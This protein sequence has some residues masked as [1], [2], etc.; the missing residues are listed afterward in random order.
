MTVQHAQIP[1]I[2]TEKKRIPTKIGDPIP[3]LKPG[4]KVV[5]GVIR[6][7][8]DESRTCYPSITTIKKYAHCG[9]KFIEESIQR[10]IN[11][12]FIEVG[13]IKLT[14]G[15]WS[16]LY[17]FPIT[18]FDK[19]FEMFTIDFL[20]QN[21]PIH[22]KEYLMDIQSSMFEKETG[23][24]KVSHSDLTISDKTG[25][26]ISEIKKFDD[27]LMNFGWLEVIPSGKVDQSGLPIMIKEFNLDAIKQAK[28]WIKAVNEQLIA[29]QNQLD[30]VDNKINAVQTKSDMEVKILQKEMNSM[31]KR[32]SNYEKILIAHGL[33]SPI[34]REY[35]MQ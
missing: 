31:Q 34:E 2:L 15:K 7:H 24:G 20:K 21:I 29:T 19:T 12:G 10:L 17:R 13:K 1:Q 25:W 28:L 32:L 30:E 35:Q 9:Q 6:M 11:A 4:D 14:N 22:L 33:I 27:A 18:E 26:S 5:Y 16:N 8:M 3:V 23:I